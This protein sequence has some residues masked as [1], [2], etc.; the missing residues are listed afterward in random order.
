MTEVTVILRLNNF[1]FCFKALNVILQTINIYLR[2]FLPCRLIIL[3][4]VPITAKFC[5]KSN[6]RCAVKKINEYLNFYPQI[7]RTSTFLLSNLQD[8]KSREGN[9]FDSKRIREKYSAMYFS[10]HP[11]TYPL[12]HARTHKQNELLYRGFVWLKP[13]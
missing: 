13:E 2:I 10:T 3:S 7:R 9:L 5:I 4:V 11:P 6:H 1:K 12:I 8:W